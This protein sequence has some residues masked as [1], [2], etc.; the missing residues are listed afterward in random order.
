MLLPVLTYASPKAGFIQ[1][2]M[3]ENSLRRDAVDVEKL[4]IV[5]IQTNLGSKSG[6]CTGYFVKN[7]NERF[8]IATAQHCAKYNFEKYCNDKGVH[9]TT[10]SG[11][12]KGFCESVLITHDK[13][14]FVIIEARF[15]NPEAVRKSIKFLTLADSVPA[16][17]TNLKLIGYPGDEERRGQITVS[18]KCQVLSTNR[19][20]MQ[21]LT[22]EELEFLGAKK[23]L[24][25]APHVQ[26]DPFRPQAVD[27]EVAA[28][29]KYAK[30]IKAYAVKKLH[31][32]SVYGG[33]SGGPLLAF[34]SDVVVGMPMNYLRLPVTRKF[35]EHSGMHFE[36]TQSFIENNR[37]AF[38]DLKIEL[39]TLP[40]GGLYF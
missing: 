38:E 39:H 26:A 9:I 2:S 16:A 7:I 36:T 22:K 33:N 35:S 30:D 6:R 20:A 5:K 11:N 32:C 10:A 15:I 14:D 27:P 18:E 28:A 34:G 29:K 31:N 8:F 3:F 24:P 40:V 21:E 13:S 37:R 23:S 4:G 12:H 1:T 25:Q 19:S 17:G